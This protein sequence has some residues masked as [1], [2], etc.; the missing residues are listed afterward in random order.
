MFSLIP[1]FRLTPFAGTPDLNSLIIAMF[2][3]TESLFNATSPFHYQ[4][5]FTFGL[6]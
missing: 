1:Y 6:D 3:S 4:K 5:K 2:F